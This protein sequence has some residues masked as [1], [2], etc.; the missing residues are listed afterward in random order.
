MSEDQGRG[1]AAPQ[2]G[3]RLFKIGALAVSLGCLAVLMAAGQGLIGCGADPSPSAAPVLHRPSVPQQA[4][5]PPLP[6]AAP[7]R[8]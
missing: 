7:S 5:Q 3:S 8:E 4:P 1:E 6:N 2:A